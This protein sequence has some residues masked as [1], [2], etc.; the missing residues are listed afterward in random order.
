MQHFALQNAGSFTN[1]ALCC[2]TC[3]DHQIKIVII[4]S[5]AVSTWFVRDETAQ[6]S[7]TLEIPLIKLYIIF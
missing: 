1:V 7:Y 6:V 3:N 4:L 5:A 2:L